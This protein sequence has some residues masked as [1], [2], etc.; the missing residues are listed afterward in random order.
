MAG[1][2]EADA[3]GAGHDCWPR[4]RRRARHCFCFEVGSQSR[5]RLKLAEVDGT[6]APFP[7]AGFPT[8]QSTLRDRRRHAA[9]APTWPESGRHALRQAPGGRR[10]PTGGADRCRRRHP[11][12]TP[13]RRGGRAATEATRIGSDEREGGRGR[14]PRKDHPKSRTSAGRPARRARR[15]DRHGPRPPDQAGT[16]GHPERPARHVCGPRGTTWSADVLPDEREE[17][18]SPRHGGAPLPSRRPPTTGATLS[19]RLRAATPPHRHRCSPSPRSWPPPWSDRC[20]GDWASPDGPRGGRGVGRDRAHR[21]RLPGVE[22]RAHRAAGRRPRRGRLLPSG[23]LAVVGGARPN[24]VG[25][26]GGIGGRSVSRL[27]RQ[28]AERGPE[29]RASRSHRARP[30][31]AHPGLSMPPRARPPPR[32]PPVRTPSDMPPATHPARHRGHR[33]IIADGRSS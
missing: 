16:P 6:S 19:R 15:A 25:R 31:P 29:P 7:G 18:D 27:R 26:R 4:R 33:W 1:P 21:L 8:P 17:V 22:G 20:G 2:D 9:L 11:D 3:R 24:R 12:P 13:G 5:R 32:L 10:S 28:R 23:T 14:G 30:P